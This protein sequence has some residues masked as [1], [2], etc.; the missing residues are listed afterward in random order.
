MN[1]KDNEV[2]LVKIYTSAGMD[3]VSFDDYQEALDAIR[4][5]THPLS[6]FLLVGNV[7]VRH[8][9]IIKVVIDK[10]EKKMIEAT[11]VLASSRKKLYFKTEVEMRDFA[12]ALQNSGADGYFESC[13][14]SHFKV[15]Q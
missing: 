11:F 13:R 1:L 9:E 8:K 7:Y 4:D 2:T 6:E 5:I 3:V 12:S 10:G 15:I 14:N